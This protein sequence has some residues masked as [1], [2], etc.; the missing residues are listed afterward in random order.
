MIR[1]YYTDSYKSGLAVTPS[2]TL[3]LDG[4]HHKARG[5]NIIYMLVIH[6]QYYQLQQLVITLLF[7]TQLM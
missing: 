4:Q 3:L 6:H 2:D 5:N 1:N 7:Q